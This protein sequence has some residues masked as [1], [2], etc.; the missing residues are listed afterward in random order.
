MFE[1]LNLLEALTP[2]EPIPE[3]LIPEKP[4]LEEPM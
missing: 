3:E 1:K 4:M 2:E